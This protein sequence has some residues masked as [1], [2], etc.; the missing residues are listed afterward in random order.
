MTACWLDP[1]FPQIHNDDR[2]RMFKEVEITSLCKSKRIEASKEF[3]N[4]PTGIL[5]EVAARV[6]FVKAIFFWYM[7]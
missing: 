1:F 3:K 4:S 7:D 2:S 5:V 6:A